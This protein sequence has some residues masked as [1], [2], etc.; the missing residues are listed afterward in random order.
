[1]QISIR[2]PTPDDQEFLLEL[3]A[4]MRVDIRQASHL[5][6]EQ[7][8]QLIESQFAAQSEHYRTHFPQADRGIVVY[9][10]TPIGRLDLNRTG[11]EIL[12]MELGLR[13]AY[14]GQGIGSQLLRA[15][16]E[17]A[18]V[19]DRRVRLHVEKQNP[20]LN[21]YLAHGFGWLGEKEMHWELQWP[22]QA[23]TPEPW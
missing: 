1:M 4:D 3:Y 21:F 11:E 15:V 13:T 8:R 19:T 16:Q 9:G 18:R 22:A 10:N 12:V 7:R 23:G 5:N 14:Q 20:A 2:P 17:E 6:P